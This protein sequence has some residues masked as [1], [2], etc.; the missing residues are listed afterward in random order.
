MVKTFAILVTKNTREVL[1]LETKFGPYI[2]ISY[3]SKNIA[4]ADAF[5]NLLSENE[6][7]CWMAPYDVP[8]GAKYAYV[9][10]QAIEKCS[11]VLLLLTKEAQESD[12]VNREI[13][14]ADTYKKEIV[15]VRLDDCTLNAGFQYYFGNRQIVT[16]TDIRKENPEVR[17]L[18]ARLRQLN[19]TIWDPLEPLFNVLD[20]WL[21]TPKT[22]KINPERARILEEVY[23]KLVA[24][25]KKEGYDADRC[26]ITIAPSPLETGDVSISFIC[27]DLTIY[28]AKAFGEIISKLDDFEIYPLVDDKLRFSGVIRKVYDVVTR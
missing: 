6:L 8:A 10:D 1:D 24:L 27:S 5:R 18:V 19:G 22:M 11:C 3:S 2:F 28:D 17:D 4:Q 21:S 13:D 23:S 25:L 16:I 15:P 9:I 26:T 14:R 12:H 20:Q 7:G